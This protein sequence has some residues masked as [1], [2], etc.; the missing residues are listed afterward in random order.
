MAISI[1]FG[2]FH[3]QV[4]FFKK[5][6]APSRTFG[7]VKELKQIQNNGLAKG[8]DMSN[9]LMVDKNKVLNQELLFE[10]E[11]AR[12]KVLDI[13]GDMALL[14]YSIKGKITARHSGHRHNIELVKKILQ[15]NG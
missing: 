3:N 4:E 6:V 10:N 9:F 14:G 1:F 13:I 5:E 7:F 15:N 8:G 2:E 12:H 11:F